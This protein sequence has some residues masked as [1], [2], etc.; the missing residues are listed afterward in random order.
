MAGGLLL[1][2]S[3]AISFDRI[4]NHHYQRSIAASAV[5]PSSTRLLNPY[6]GIRAAEVWPPGIKVRATGKVKLDKVGEAV[7]RFRREIG[8]GLGVATLLMAYWATQV[9]I[10]TRFLDAMK[11]HCKPVE[12]ARLGVLGRAHLEKVLTQ[13]G[14]G[15]VK[16]RKVADFDEHGLP[17]V[18]E[19]AFGVKKGSDREEDQ[20]EHTADRRRLIVG[21]NWSPVLKIPATSIEDVL[22]NQCLVGRNDPVVYLLNMAHP[23]FEFT[24]HGKGALADE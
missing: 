7:L 24:D 6:K 12:P 19:V 15:A 3:P 14:A 22:G 18:V 23:H 5:G 1:C 9:H 20:E 2:Q 17:F 16:Y 13:R 8:I 21:M 10:S 4:R 11:G